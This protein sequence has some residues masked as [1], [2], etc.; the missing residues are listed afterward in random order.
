MYGLSNRLEKKFRKAEKNGCPCLQCSLGAF[1]QFPVGQELGDSH[2][3]EVGQY[4]HIDLVGPFENS[5]GGNR[6]ALIANDQESIFVIDHYVKG[7]DVATII[8]PLL[9]WLIDTIKS[10]DKTP[11]SF[12]FDADSIFKADEGKRFLASEHILF[13]FSEPGE[14]RH[15]GA[16]ERAW[17]EYFKRAYARCWLVLRLKT[18]SGHMLC[19]K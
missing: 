10:K 4:W 6:F 18:S 16:V 19:T 2:S 5:I 14:H 8:I 3:F 12:H 9:K 7:K 13:G 11:R 1:H 17:R 15:S